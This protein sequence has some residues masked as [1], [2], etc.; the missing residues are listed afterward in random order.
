MKAIYALVISGLLVMSGTLHAGHEGGM[1]GDDLRKTAAEYERH[2]DSATRKATNARGEDVNRYLELS[3]VYEE[4]AQ[5]KRLAAEKGDQGRWNDMKWGRYH[6]LESRRDQLLEQLDWSH[7]R[8]KISIE[9]NSGPDGFI[10][11]ARK[12]ESLARQTREDARD[13]EGPARNMFEE[14]AKIYDEM[15]VI[16]HEAAASAKRGRDIKWSHYHSLEHRRDELKN[17]LNQTSYGR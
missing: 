11:E 9:D 17:Q 8:K 10:K 3:S 16:K 7:T 5:I 1:P 2:A 6:Q 12:C 14:L 15:A 13:A 4:M